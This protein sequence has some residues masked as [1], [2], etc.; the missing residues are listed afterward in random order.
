M[1]DTLLPVAP[2]SGR[3]PSLD[4]LI[5]GSRGLA[6]AARR[7]FYGGRGAAISY[8]T[9]CRLTFEQHQS[10][11]EH[12]CFESAGGFAE[13]QSGTQRL[14]SG[15]GPGRTVPHCEL[16][17]DYVEQL[18]KHRRSYLGIL[19]SGEFDDQPDMLHVLRRCFAELQGLCRHAAAADL[20]WRSFSIRWEESGA[21]ELHPPPRPALVRRRKRSA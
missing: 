15:Y 10:A 2:A 5:E 19:D 13:A 14:Y 9:A 12:A 1:I 18:R 7:H 20:E 21:D 17:S 8:L 3:S 16:L 6:R 4:T 11:I